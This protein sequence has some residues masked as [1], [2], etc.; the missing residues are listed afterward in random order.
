M[1]LCGTCR[2]RDDC[3]AWEA[4]QSDWRKDLMEKF[5]CT[6]WEP[7]AVE[8]EAEVGCRTPERDGDGWLILRDAEPRNRLRELCE[9]QRVHVVITPL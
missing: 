9:G 4:V 5:G 2:D 7:E 6:C 8:F 1:K 3:A